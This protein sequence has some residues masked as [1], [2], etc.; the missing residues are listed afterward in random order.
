[1]NAKQGKFQAIGNPRLVIY[2]AQ[3]ILDHAHRSYKAGVSLTPERARARSNSPG[4]SEPRSDVSPA[5]DRSF[6][7][8][9][10]V[11][12]HPVVPSPLN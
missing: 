3:I 8:F 12:K 4:A 7:N 11:G 5:R 6:R 9:V 10:L 2:V 1:V